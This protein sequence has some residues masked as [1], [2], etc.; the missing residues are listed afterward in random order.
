MTM[1]PTDIDRIGASWQHP[2]DLMEPEEETARHR[3]RIRYLQVLGHAMEWIRAANHSEVGWWQVVYAFGLNQAAKPMA[4]VAAELGIERATI[5]SGA[6]KLLVA[7]DMPPSQAMRSEEA[8]RSYS[9][10]RKAKLKKP[11]KK[12]NDN[13]TKR[14][15]RRSVSQRNH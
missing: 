10:R 2:V 14:N 3:D 5:S 1:D 9:D 12:R 15:A 8:V 4:E 11:K 6:R 7:L 13:S